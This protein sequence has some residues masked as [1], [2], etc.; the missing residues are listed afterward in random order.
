[1][2]SI[3]LFCLLIL[4]SLVFSFC[5]TEEKTETIDKRET[6]KLFDG[7]L[8]L[9]KTY[10]DS[11]SAAEDTTVVAEL[12]RNFNHNLEKLNFE[13]APDTDLTLSE[14]QN[15]SL[16]TKLTE[17]RSLYEKKIF[18]LVYPDGEPTDSVSSQTQEGTPE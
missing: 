1:M 10:T 13:V 5:Q 3:K 18:D 7:T 16:Y 2:K 6:K 9:I 14:Q 4:T 17:F 15:D 8:R 11:I 12:F